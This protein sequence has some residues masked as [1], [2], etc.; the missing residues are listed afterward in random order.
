MPVLPF[1]VIAATLRGGRRLEDR[2]DRRDVLSKSDARP[3]TTNAKQ[4]IQGL[5]PLKPRR[6]LSVTGGTDAPSSFEHINVNKHFDH[7]CCPHYAT[8]PGTLYADSTLTDGR[9][10]I[11]PVKLR[12]QASARG[13]DLEP[14]SANYAKVIPYDDT[15]SGLQRNI[16]VFR[17]SHLFVPGPLN[18]VW[19]NPPGSSR[20]T[21]SQL[22][23]G[24][25][26]DIDTGSIYITADQTLGTHIN[27]F[28]GYPPRLSLHH[29]VGIQAPLFFASPIRGHCCVFSRRSTTGLDAQRS[30]Q[31]GRHDQLRKVREGPTAPETE[32]VIQPGIASGAYASPGFQPMN[33]HLQIYAPPNYPIIPVTIYADG[34]LTDDQ[35]P[36]NPVKL[37]AQ[38]S[39]R[40]DDLEPNSGNY[41]KVIPYDETVPGL[42]CSIWHLYSTSPGPVDLV[43]TNPPGSL[44]PTAS[45]IFYGYTDDIDAGSIYI[46]N[47]AVL[48]RAAAQADTPGL[49]VAN[50]QLF[51][52]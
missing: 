25:T 36:N 17:L 18:L 42:Q 33:G 11:S 23:Y 47:N 50:L 38:A 44:T 45:T 51:F 26:D 22:F 21:A 24:C 6:L 5:P 43:W 52:F 34:T 9:D 2:H 13:D 32:K 1:A 46:T 40:G 8:I 15:I 14:N 16:W 29:G 7:L 49:Q 20:P 12:A 48:G 37:C 30:P 28:P 19:S 4:F 31:G 3:P 10:P 27:P 41:A 35:N 39:A